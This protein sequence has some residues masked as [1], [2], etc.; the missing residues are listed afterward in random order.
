MQR[1]STLRLVITIS[2]VILTINGELLQNLKQNRCQASIFGSIHGFLQS[3]T[4]QTDF[5]IERVG[6]TCTTF[7]DRQPFCPHANTPLLLDGS[8]AF[9]AEP[10]TGTVT[11]SSAPFAAHVGSVYTG[12]AAT[13]VLLAI[14]QTSTEATTFT[15]TF[16]YADIMS[17]MGYE[18]V[19]HF[20]GAN[21]VAFNAKVEVFGTVIFDGTVTLPA[22]G[23]PPV[24]DTK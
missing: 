2:F 9:T 21:S 3:V 6:I 22:A 20:I 4:T 12:S 5:R 10:N 17:N 16:Q 18:G 15:Y 7:T 19:I 8:Q 13:G 23:V 24:T 1:R 14:Q 11:F